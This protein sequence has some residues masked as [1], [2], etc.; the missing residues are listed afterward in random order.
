MT[1]NFDI[2][3]APVTLVNLVTTES[4]EVQFNP[5]Q[6]EEAFGANFA[7]LVVPGLSHQRKHFVHTEEPVYTFDLFNHCLGSGQTGPA[8][9]QT[10][11]AARRFLMALAHPWRGA[12]SIERGGSPR[13]LFI[14]PQLISLP[15]K[16]TKCVF[17]YTM[18]SATS[19]P[20]LWNA[21]VT[22][23]V[24]R[25]EF[26]SMEDILNGGTGNEID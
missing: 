15:C 20:T 4:L 14:W 17:R 23:E 19:A 26:V 16:L 11:R 1:Q 21:K 3:P 13:V 18:F 6:L 22:L 7:K 25:D 9:M 12:E 10:I 8:A 24:D 5:E 2:K